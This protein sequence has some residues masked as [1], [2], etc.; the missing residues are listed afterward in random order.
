MW[1]SIIQ[2]LG[3]G[4]SAV[5]EDHIYMARICLRCSSRMDKLRRIRW[6]G[7]VALMGAGQKILL[8]EN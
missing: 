1:R 2:G 4:D 8:Y 6:A 7:H 3:T 5:G